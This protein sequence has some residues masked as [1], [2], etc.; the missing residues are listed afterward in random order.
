MST[1]YVFTPESAQ[2][3]STNFAPLTLVNRRPALAF[4]KA[5]DETVYFSA[6]APQNI[7]GTLTVVISYIMAS[8][9]TGNIYC[10]A[11]IDAVSDGDATNLDSTTSFDTQYSGNG[12][13]P[14]TAGYIDQISITM[15]SSDSIAAGDYFRL[16]INRDANNA[17]D[18]AAGDAYLLMVEL[19][20]GS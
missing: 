15:T 19:R 9:T 4:D 1:I 2:F 14:A 6:I 10:Q 16:A 3:P 7:T 5:T 17:S 18:T 12:A 20:D 8:A 11:A 13:V